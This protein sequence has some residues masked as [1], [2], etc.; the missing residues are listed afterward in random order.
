MGHWSSLRSTCNSYQMLVPLCPLS[1]FHLRIFLPGPLFAWKWCF[2]P[3]CPLTIQSPAKSWYLVRLLH[4]SPASLMTAYR[5][6]LDICELEHHSARTHHLPAVMVIVFFF[7]MNH[8]PS[9]S[10]PVCLPYL[11]FC[12]S[13]IFQTTVTQLRVKCWF[14]HYGVVVHAHTPMNK[15]YSHLLVL[16]A[17]DLLFG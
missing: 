9:L 16:S 11:Y 15:N 13:F 3:F 7:K 17:P 6:I 2:K 4:L 1:R 10:S 8:H 12:H 14:L 5:C